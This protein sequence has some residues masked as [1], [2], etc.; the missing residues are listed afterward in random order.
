MICFVDLSALSELMNLELM[1]PML[2]S[3]L[4]QIYIL[5]KRLTE[6]A[7]FRFAWENGV[8]LVSLVLPTVAGPFLTPS[9]PTSIQL[10][11]S[12]ITGTESRHRS[13]DPSQSQNH[14]LRCS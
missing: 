10:L 5:S 13:F 11:L 9:V 8:H 1:N 4:L 3:D 14:R 12:P 6:E 7:A 2:A